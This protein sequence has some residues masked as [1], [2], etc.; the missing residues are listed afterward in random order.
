MNYTHKEKIR[1]YLSK[2][3]LLNFARNVYRIRYFLR[4]LK[5]R[6]FAFFRS[7][8]FYDNRFQKLKSLKQKY[9]GQRCFIISTGPSLKLEDIEKLNNE[10]TFS[11]NSIIMMF[12]KTNWRPTFYG[13]QDSNVYAKFQPYIM[14]NKFAMMLFSD[15][16]LTEHCIPE[17]ENS[18]IFPLNYLNH[19]YTKK[20]LEYKFSDDAYFSVYDGATITYSL[21]EIAVYMG[22]KEIYLLGCDC[23]YS[24]SKKHFADYGFVSNDNPESRMIAAYKKAKEYADSH[25]IKIYNATRGGKLEVFERV[26]FDSL[27]PED[28][29]T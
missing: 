19:R 18:I 5:S 10:I 9:S 11:M 4:D 20:K 22:F 28:D 12:E 13:I 17:T 23:D 26:D 16:L 24:G 1:V 7:K 8:G 15:Y 21:I 25:N 2:Y 6:L 29:K 3:N 14:K 27:F